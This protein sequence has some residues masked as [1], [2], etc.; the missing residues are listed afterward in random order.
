MSA[1]YSKAE[2]QN[3]LNL[4]N[5]DDTSFAHH[6]NNFKNMIK[7]KFGKL[8][9]LKE[10]LDELYP[11]DLDNLK[12][13]LTSSDSRVSTIYNLLKGNQIEI[14]FA[15]ISSTTSSFAIRPSTAPTVTYTRSPSPPIYH[16][17]HTIRVHHPHIMIGGHHMLPMMGGGIP[18]T[19]GMIVHSNGTV[20]HNVMGPA[21]GI[22]RL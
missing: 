6:C 19:R 11:N 12:D 9:N 20:T 10:W 15:K 2:I 16:K 3:I 18:M 17:H 5:L 8:M 14:N 1:H 4:L 13:I 7:S 21:G 22:F